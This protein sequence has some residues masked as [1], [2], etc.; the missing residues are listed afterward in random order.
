LAGQKAMG[1]IFTQSH[2]RGCLLETEHAVPSVFEASVTPVHRFGGVYHRLI[3]AATFS[4][5]LPG[6]G[7]PRRMSRRIE[8]SPGS[9]ATWGIFV[10]TLQAGPLG[11]DIT[12]SS[13]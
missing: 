1:R 5:E 8:K 6:I 9:R 12:R 13:K 3:K 2:G 4:A 11:S 7:D 10:P